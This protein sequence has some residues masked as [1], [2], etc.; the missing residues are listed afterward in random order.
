MFNSQL[1]YNIS[2]KAPSAVFTELKMIISEAKLAYI[3]NDNCFSKKQAK[4]T[5]VND[6]IW[7]DL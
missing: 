2:I 6:A 3:E 4:Y 5:V 7:I 1:Y